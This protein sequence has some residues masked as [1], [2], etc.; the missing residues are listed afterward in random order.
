MLGQQLLVQEQVLGMWV[1]LHEWDWTGC[2]HDVSLK[3]ELMKVLAA[4]P[5][6]ELLLVLE[7]V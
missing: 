4:S 5:M 2:D 1:L 7:V 3:V 6:A